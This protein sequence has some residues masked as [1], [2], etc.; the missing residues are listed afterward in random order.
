MQTFEEDTVNPLSYMKKHNISSIFRFILTHPDM[1]YMDGI[2]DLF[3]EFKPSNFWDIDNTKFWGGGNFH[4]KSDWD[5]YCQIRDDPL[6]YDIK[7]LTLYSGSEGAYY[8]RDHNGTQG[9]GLFIL[10][11]T[12][13]LVRRENYSRDYNDASYVILYC[14]NA[15]KIIIS[16]DSHDETWEYI[17]NEHRDLVSNI[18]ILIAPHHGRKSGRDHKFLDILKPQLTLF[19]DAP[20][21]HLSYN[22]YYYRELPFITQ[23]Q[24]G[25]VVIDTNDQMMKVYV[26][27]KIRDG[28]NV[29]PHKYGYLFCTI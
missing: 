23:K 4:G 3:K 26:S 6:S 28:T 8:N 1:D 11:P 5:F 10:A 12:R 22:S 29:L 18:K 14:S 16:G 7:R 17:R 9:D 24:A 19:G 21:E 20:S 13:E 25:S 27:K 15:G 2:E